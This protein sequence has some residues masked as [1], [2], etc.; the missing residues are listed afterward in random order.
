M[1]E[2]AQNS[3]ALDYPKDKL[4]ILFITDGSDDGTPD[5]LRNIGGVEVTHENRRA[6]KAAAENR[7]MQLVNTPIVVFCDANTQ[8]NPACIRELVKFYQDPKVGGVAGEKRVLSK[9]KDNAGGAG[10]GFYW[11]YESKLKKWDSELHTVVGAA[12]ELIS[13]RSEL[14]TDLEEDTIL[15][16]FMQS[17]R[18]CEKGYTVKYEP[19]AVA[20]ETASENVGEELK[21]K[22]RIAAGGWQSMSRLLSLLNPFRHS[23]LSF[24]Y[25]SHRVLRWSVAAFALP[26]ILLLNIALLEHHM[27]YEL[28][29]LFQLI[30]YG[31]AILGW[32]LENRQIRIKL[33][34]IPYYFSTDELR[35]VCRFCT[36]AKRWPKIYLAKR[37]NGPWLRKFKSWASGYSACKNLRLLAAASVRASYNA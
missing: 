17:L 18:I 31:L 7:A 2:K 35:S 20:L 28:T 10:E 19:K 26:V 3:L 11:K 12:G 27:V 24:Q 22:V 25:T 5:V 16:D 6:G 4:R 29:M 14:M 15:D 37:P 8:L 13:F 9:E 33:L 21:R 23:L 1:E 34:F 32:I 30:F 36:L